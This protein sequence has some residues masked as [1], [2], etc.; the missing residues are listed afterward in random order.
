MAMPAPIALFVYRRFDLVDHVLDALEL[1]P[2]FPDSDIYIYSDGPK[3]EAAAHDVEQVRG[4]IKQRQ[5]PNI[6]LIEAQENRGL[7]TS[8]IAGVSE[9]CTQYGRV[10]VLEDDLIV[11]P[12]LLRWFNDALDAY[13]NDEVVMQVAGH[14]FGAPVAGERGFFAP[15]TT[16]WGWA[17]WDRAWR[18]FDAD[19]SG[20]EA[21]L[22]DGRL[23]RR[24]DFDGCYPFTA[25]MQ[26]QREGK[27]D[28]WAIRWYW[29]VFCKNGIVAYPPRT[30]I[31][32]IGDDERATHKGLRNQVR[33][34]LK[35]K[36]PSQELM[37]SPP[38]LP[39]TAKLDTVASMGLQREIRRSRSILAAVLSRFSRRPR[40]APSSQEA[41]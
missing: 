24:F 37:H 5:R 20:W 9:L 27:V 30:L 7:A 33:S 16:S 26:K 6:R 35:V 2:E 19:A 29:S 8:I 32:N 18:A 12:H 21:L 28:S 34:W 23:R 31:L 3:S 10:I 25:M 11:S 1:C 13:A 4:A 14:V 38:R 40:T 22:S 17:T 41:A 36:A 39:A 15:I